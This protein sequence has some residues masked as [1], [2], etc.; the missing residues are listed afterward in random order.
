MILVEKDEAMEI[1]KEAAYE[2]KDNFG[3]IDNF[4]THSEATG[5]MNEAN[6]IKLGLHPGYLIEAYIKGLFHDYGRPYAKDKKAHTFHEIIGARRFEADAVDLGITDSQKQANRIAQA[7][8]SHFLVSE[9]FSMPKYKKWLPGLRDTNPDLLL[10]KSIDELSLVCSD[11][12]N[13]GGKKIP[14]EDRL[15]DIKM[16]DEEAK[17][18]RLEVV[19]KAEKRLIKIKEDFESMLEAGRVDT[20]NYPL[21]RRTVA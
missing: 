1:L 13:A 6:A 18:P 4:F 16:R 2:H 8:R 11:L 21:Y 9:Q 17:S 10:P 5:R 12:T 7:S 14:F 3:N 19:V 15:A 20:T